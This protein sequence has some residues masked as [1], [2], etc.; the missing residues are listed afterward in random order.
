M[1]ITNFQVQNIIKAYRVQSAVRSRL[2]REK[3]TKSVIPRDEVTL[4]VES[5]KR[6]LAEKITQGVMQQILRGAERN[7]TIAQALSRLSQ[8]YGKDLSFEVENEET[9][10]FSEADIN[11]PGETRLL[12][13]EENQELKGRLFDI[14]KSMVYDNLI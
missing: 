10:V 11:S 5:K 6:L 9:M 14:A 4:S 7:E 2:A 12:S 8:E 1:T 3:V 13:L